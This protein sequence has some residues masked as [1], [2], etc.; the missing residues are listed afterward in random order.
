MDEKPSEAEE[1]G[2][3]ISLICLCRR[4]RVA[5]GRAL[6]T[7]GG[8][9]GIFTLVLLCVHNKVKCMYK[10]YPQKEY[11]DIGRMKRRFVARADCGDRVQGGNCDVC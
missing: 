6:H 9:F 10:T 8:G 5:F 7:F 4:R 1:F 11:F 2:G 3:N